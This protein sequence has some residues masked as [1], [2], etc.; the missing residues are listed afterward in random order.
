M[1]Q[2][3]SGWEKETN[4]SK[5]EFSGII[6]ICKLSTSTTVAPSPLQADCCAL[7][8]TRKA[9]FQ[10]L[11]WTHLWIWFPGTYA[12]FKLEDFDLN[13]VYGWCTSTWAIFPH[14]PVV[15]THLSTLGNSCCSSLLSWGACWDQLVELP[16]LPSG[17]LRH[18]TCR[19][20]HRNKSAGKKRRIPGWF[21]RLLNCVTSLLFTALPGAF[22]H[23]YC[24][25]MKDPVLQIPG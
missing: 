12:Q 5:A 15:M 7:Q 9:S 1:H 24:Q 6:I 3:S 13:T 14:A 16:L 17:E 11:L 4:W 23:C 22:A 19:E 21:P 10:R 18:F 8:S 20:A 2:I 25:G